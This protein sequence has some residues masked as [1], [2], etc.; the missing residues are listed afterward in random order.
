MYGTR[1][2]VTHNSMGSQSPCHVVVRWSSLARVLHWHNSKSHILQQFYVQAQDEGFSNF[3]ED[4]EW[5]RFLAMLR[6][7][8]SL[9]QEALSDLQ[10][11]LYLLEQQTE[12]LRRWRQD[13]CDLNQVTESATIS[14]TD[15]MDVFDTSVDIERSGSGL[16]AMATIGRF[17][18][19]Y[20]D[21]V[22]NDAEYGLD[23]R[24]AMDELDGC[25]AEKLRVIAPPKPKWF[26]CAQMSP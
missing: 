25:E 2:R 8:Y 17:S 15:E 10:G 1:V 18:I 11:N 19:C 14:D 24:N 9:V 13:N 6:K 7:H 21:I 5:W 16:S 4:P 3:S 22:A 23:A 26:R 12:K 20:A